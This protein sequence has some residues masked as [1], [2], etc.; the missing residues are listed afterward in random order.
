M[1]LTLLPHM[2]NFTLQNDRANSE[3]R[4]MED[5]RDLVKKGREQ[6]RKEL[7]SIKPEV[8]IGRRVGE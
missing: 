2:N 3:S 7:E 5:Y 6:F 4:L 1:P 8:R